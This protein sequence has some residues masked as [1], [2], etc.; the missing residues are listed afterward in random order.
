MLV[1]IETSFFPFIVFCISFLGTPTK[2]QMIK[3]SPN[4]PAMNTADFMWTC[5]GSINLQKI[6]FKNTMRNTKATKLTNWLLCNSAYDLEPAAFTMAPEIL[7]IGP[8]F[9]GNPPGDSAGNFWPED[10]TCLKWLDQQQP[11]SVIYVAFGSSTFLD[12]TQFHELAFGLELCNKPFI[13]VVRPGITYTVDDA[14][15]KGFRHRVSGRGKIVDWAPQLKILDHPSVACFISHCGW[16]STIEALSCGIPLLCWPYIVDQFHNES[17]I[18]DTWKVGLRLNKD[19]RV[20]ITPEEIKNKVEKLVGNGKYKASALAFKEMIMRSI[21]EGGS[22]YNNF[23]TF[24]EW[25]KS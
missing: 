20:I 23:N 12:Q 6:I 10:L 9:V 7:P 14:Y 11:Q 13:W 18:C 2:R 16:N 15:P 25:L 19:E 24:I 22:S 4:M 17:Y 1:K 8:L 21:K 3:L 5:T